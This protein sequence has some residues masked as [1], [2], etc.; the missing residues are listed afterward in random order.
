[1]RQEKASCV[2]YRIEFGRRLIV[3]QQ[4]EWDGLFTK[5]GVVHVTACVLG[6]RF[7]LG[8]TGLV[9]YKIPGAGVNWYCLDGP[10]GRRSADR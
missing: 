6:L 7:L 3:N 9:S 4:W 5:D 10:S 1:M 2:L 8:L